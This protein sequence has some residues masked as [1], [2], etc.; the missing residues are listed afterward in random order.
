MAQIHENISIFLKLIEGIYYK[1]SWVF[2]ELKAIR[3]IY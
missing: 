3:C 1:V 2:Y